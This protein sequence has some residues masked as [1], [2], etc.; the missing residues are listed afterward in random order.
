LARHAQSLA[1]YYDAQFY[2]NEFWKKE[3]ARRRLFE[4]IPLWK[5]PTKEEWNKAKVKCAKNYRRWIGKNPPNEMRIRDG[6]FSSKKIS[7]TNPQEI[8]GYLSQKYHYYLGEGQYGKPTLLLGKIEEYN[9]LGEIQELIIS[10][11]IACNISLI[12]PAIFNIIP[13]RAIGRLTPV[14]HEIWRWINALEYEKVSKPRLFFIFESFSHF[15]IEKDKLKRKLLKGS[16]KVDKI[17][18]IWLKNSIMKHEEGHYVVSEMQRFPLETLGRAVE[19]ARAHR[20]GELEDFIRAVHDSLADTVQVGEIKGRYLSILDTEEPY[21]TGLLYSTLMTIV[22]PFRYKLKV[23][24]TLES[25]MII[26]ACDYKETR[27][28]SILRLANKKIFDRSSIYGRRIKKDWNKYQTLLAIKEKAYEDTEKPRENAE[29]ALREL[30]STAK[31][32]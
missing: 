21:R 4:R 30:V 19:T 11:E 2:E 7:L 6:V 32:Y 3:E 15:G 1:D 14:K 18:E 24:L 26:A 13:K 8:N 25:E 23:L 27:D 29:K 5:Y 9:E 31:K 22:T 16:S 10:D 12:T 20:N 28:D 17:A